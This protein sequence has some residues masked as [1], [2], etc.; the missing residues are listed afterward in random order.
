MMSAE[1][2]AL[3]KKHGYRAQK[4]ADGTPEWQAAGLPLAES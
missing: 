4:I 1:A 3:L 2:V